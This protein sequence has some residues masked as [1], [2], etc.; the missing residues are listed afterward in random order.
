MWCT[1]RVTTNHK[2][3]EMYKD[4]DDVV[5]NGSRVYHEAFEGFNHDL[6]L[7]KDPSND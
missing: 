1:N 7:A 6:D 2:T 5:A 3:I 4:R